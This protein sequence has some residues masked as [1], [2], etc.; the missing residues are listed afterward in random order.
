MAQFNHGVSVPQ[1]VGGYLKR[2]LKKRNVTQEEFSYEFGVDVRTVRRW[3][4]GG[5][6]SLDVVVEIARYFGV[7]VVDV[8]SDED[9]VPF[10]LR[11]KNKEI[12]LGHLL[13]FRNLFCCVIILL[14]NRDKP[15]KA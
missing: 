12:P 15:I 8:L 3:V 2:E 9:G 10:Y 13:S 4:S 14:S 11:K 7:S 6:H 5:I 1:S